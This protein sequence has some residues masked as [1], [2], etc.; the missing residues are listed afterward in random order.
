[1]VL[2]GGRW[3]EL[4]A[5]MRMSFVVSLSC[6]GLALLAVTSVETATARTPW[7]DP[8][9]QGVWTSE[10]EL[11]VPF[12]RPERFGDR[13]ELTDEEFA[14]RQAQAAKQ[15]ATDNAEFDVE[16]ANTANAGSVGSATSPPPHWLE[17]GKPSRR[18]SLVI[19]PANGRIPP[20]TDAAKSRP[21]ARGGVSTNANAN[22]PFNSW[23]DMG[24]YDRCIT[25]G[26]PGA[27]FPAIYNA[28]TRIVQGPGSVAITYEMIH[29]TRIIPIGNASPLSSTVRQYVG[30][31][32][33]RWEGDTLVV[34]SSNYPLTGGYRG[35][36]PDATIVERFSRTDN[37]TLR[38]EIT[39]NDPSTWTAPWTA[40]LNMTPQADGMYEYACHEGNLSMRN[41]LSGARAAERNGSR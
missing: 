26:I 28:N 23:L 27:I 17:R 19:A 4:E 39:V 24:L 7:G 32:R 20:M 6:V 16:T 29:E 10:S 14:E 1:V 21:R 13:L 31:S 18:T 22:G 8:D 5:Q 15:L 33:G 37:D 9:L 40:A 25:R 3:K 12:E 41:I 35:S 30:S 11:G 38:Y 36:S 34:E 2:A